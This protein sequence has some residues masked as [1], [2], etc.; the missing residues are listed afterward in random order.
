MNFI[1]GKW[2]TTDFDGRTGTAVNEWAAGKHCVVCKA[3]SQGVHSSGIVGWDPQE[4]VIVET[5]YQSSGKQYVNRVTD[6]SEKGWDFKGIVKIPNEETVTLKLKIAIDPDGN[7]FTASREDGATVIYQ[8]LAASE[9][10][11]K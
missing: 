5:W 3:V 1:V 8:R 11:G 4:N 10:T 6:F 9:E 7:G 2:N